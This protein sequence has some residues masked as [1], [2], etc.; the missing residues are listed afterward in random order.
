VVR[1]IAISLALVGILAFA[2]VA[3]G[4]SQEWT[5]KFRKG[6]TVSFRL[7]VPEPEEQRYVKRWEWHNLKIK[8]TN[9]R[10]RH[11]GRFKRLP[12]D[13]DPKDRTFFKKAENDYG[14]KAIL[15]GSFDETFTTAT[16]TFKIRGR[17]Y[18]GRKCRGESKWTAQGP[19]P[20]PE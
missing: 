10:H 13:V 8:C 15:R 7:T 12:L 16:G 19:P 6:G 3:L 20:P 5:G 17:T 4:E 9:G 18:A 11:D 2:G 1:R 14:G